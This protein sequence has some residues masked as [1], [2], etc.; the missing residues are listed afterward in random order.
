MEHGR[1]R[2]A[3]VASVG[4]LA[5]SEENSRLL[6]RRALRP[7]CT[8]FCCVFVSRTF[9]SFTLLRPSTADPDVRCRWKGSH[10]VGARGGPGLKAPRSNDGVVLDRGNACCGAHLWNEM[11][12]RRSPVCSFWRASPKRPR[13]T[14]SQQGAGRDTCRSGARGCSEMLSVC[15]LQQQLCMTTTR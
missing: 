12:M 9:S 5:L 1:F 8:V 4:A 10:A 6:P 11:Q 3:L 7:V 15:S 2:R 13:S 14:S